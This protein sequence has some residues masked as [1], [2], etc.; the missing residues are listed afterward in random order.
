MTRW[1][2]A[3]GGL[4]EHSHGT[5]RRVSSSLLEDAL[6]PVASLPLRFSACR[7]FRGVDVVPAFVAHAAVPM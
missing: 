3:S 4:L 1:A 6:S 5:L 2:D 7:A